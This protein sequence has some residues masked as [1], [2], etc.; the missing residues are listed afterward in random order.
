MP[1]M[2]QQQQIIT[3]H[4]QRQIPV[5]SG[6][7][8][9]TSVTNVNTLNPPISG[10]NRSR[11]NSQQTSPTKMRR[12][13]SNMVTLTD[14]LTV[15][16]SPVIDN[17]NNNNNV[18]PQFN[19]PVITPPPGRMQWRPRGRKNSHATKAPRLSLWKEQI[20]NLQNYHQRQHGKMQSIPS[21]AQFTEHN[22][23][24]VPG[25]N[26]QNGHVQNRQNDQNSP[27][28]NGV[29]AGGSPSMSPMA[30]LPPSSRSPPFAS[31]MN[32]TYDIGDCV[33]VDD[34][35]LGQIKSI[36]QHP[37][38]GKGT[39][40]GIRLTEKIGNSDGEFK[41]QRTFSCPPGY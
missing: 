8:A 41:G 33:F 22:N 36:G 37:A 34:S 39:Y 21:N 19:Q 1:S 23:L 12:N 32:V 29:G 14:V 11:S 10:H 26:G 38:W 4:H 7:R 17:D 2:M 30:A 6:Q 27:S 9:A 25:Q 15:S 13:M 20:N 31:F 28:L 16:R 24:F 35:K 40:Y 3:P 18:F 5:P